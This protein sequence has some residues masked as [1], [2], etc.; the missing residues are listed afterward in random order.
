MHGQQDR[1]GA[2][3]ERWELQV[4]E[5]SQD[6]LEGVF[7]Q[8]WRRDHRRVADIGHQV[9]NAERLSRTRHG[10]RPRSAGDALVFASRDGS[11]ERGNAE[12]SETIVRKKKRQEGNELS[13]ATYDG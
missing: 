11:F 1:G 12:K 10:Y 5:A 13:R 6:F 8:W 7:G 9:A 2:V 3:L 4:G